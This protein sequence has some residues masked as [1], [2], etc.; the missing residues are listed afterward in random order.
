M[1][2]NEEQNPIRDH[3]QSAAELRHYLRQ[4]A[5][6]HNNYKAYGPFERIA[7][8][9]DNR[10]LYLGNGKDWNDIIDCEDFNRADCPHINFGKCFSFSGDENVALW[11]LYGGMDQRA[12]MIDFTKKGMQ[13]ILAA[14]RIELGHFEKNVFVSH[15][16]LQRDSFNLYVT[17]VVY[18]KRNS[19]SVYIKR[20]NENAPT[21]Q[22]EVL[23]ELPEC[24]KSYPWQYENECRLIVSVDRRSVP[25]DCDTVKIDLSGMELGKSFERIYCGPNYP[26]PVPE[27]VKASSLT[28]KVSWNLCKNCPCLHNRKDSDK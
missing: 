12:G 10:S 2:K 6:G 24:R 17:D 3:I 28:G 26:S 8:I 1:E 13:S 5:E 23:D 18:C 22:P 14:E 7:A 27:N 16:T 11:M 20:Y 19:N 25:E 15:S 4:K 9:R 21:V